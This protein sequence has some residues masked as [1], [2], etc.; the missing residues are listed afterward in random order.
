MQLIDFIVGAIF[1]S[2]LSD[3]LPKDI[4]AAA[5]KA[6]LPKSSLPALIFD[7]VNND[8]KA[9]P[10]IPGI[11]PKIIA[12]AVDALKEAYLHSFRSVWIAACCF[13]AVGFICK[14]L[15]LTMVRLD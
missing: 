2:R 12:D 15:P 13:A 8:T 11:T 10:K 5:S 4:G 3:K 9:L 6:G 7:L 14:S 1:H